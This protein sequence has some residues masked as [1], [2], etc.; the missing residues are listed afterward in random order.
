MK[1]P[2]ELKQKFRMKAVEKK[3]SLK[4]WFQGLKNG[5]AA[6]PNFFAFF[7]LVVQRLCS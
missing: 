2:P 3:Q 1:T 5:T 7:L 6:G 4:K